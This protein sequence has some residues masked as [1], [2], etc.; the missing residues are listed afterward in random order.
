[1]T[2][3]VFDGGLFVGRRDDFSVYFFLT[4]TA[5]G[6]DTPQAVG[7][8]KR[9]GL[10]F[11]WG[12]AD[13]TNYARVVR[14]LKRSPRR[15]AAPFCPLAPPCSLPANRDGQFFLHIQTCALLE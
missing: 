11:W 8:D 3:V 14:T 9:S 6:V 2:S 10:Q 12:G 13:S 15:P 4:V 1:M 7:W 5:C